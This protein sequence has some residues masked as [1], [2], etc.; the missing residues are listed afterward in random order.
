MKT[1]LFVSILALLSSPAHAMPACFWVDTQ[2]R[3]IDLS[4]MCG[5]ERA[6]SI[7]FVSVASPVTQP[8]IATPVPTQLQ[9]ALPSVT[10]QFDQGTETIR[11]TATN[12]QRNTPTLNAISRV[13]VRYLVPS[14]IDG[15]W[16]NRSY[17]AGSVGFASFT[18]GIEQ[19]SISVS[20]LPDNARIVGVDVQVVAR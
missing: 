13:Q 11:L 8:I 16:L 4:A 18:G 5:N 1:L 6:S 7:P 19:R 10:Y 15:Q 3:T 20:Q 9:G 12:P 14:A 17:D 2:G